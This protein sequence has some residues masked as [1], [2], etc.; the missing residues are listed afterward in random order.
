MHE[1]GQRKSPGDRRHAS[2]ETRDESSLDNDRRGGDNAS[3]R[4]SR[5]RRRREQLALGPPFRV[6]GSTRNATPVRCRRAMVSDQPRGRGTGVLPETK[7]P[8]TERGNAMRSRRRRPRGP[9]PNM[10]G[11]SNPGGP[12]AEGGSSM[13]AASAQATRPGGGRRRRRSRR[14]RPNNS[15]PAPYSN[16]GGP[17]QMQRPR[18]MRGRGNG[19]PEKRRGLEILRDMQQAGVALDPPEP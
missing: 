16:S 1:R 12:P 5:R 8:T 19:R 2:P 3:A 15:A 6:R 10:P 17:P 11:S 9:R 7:E 13:G 4:L 14:G 18:G